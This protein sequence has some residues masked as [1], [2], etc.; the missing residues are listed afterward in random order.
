VVADE[1]TLA[2]TGLCALDVIYESADLR[3]LEQQV[4]AALPQL[5]IETPLD[6]AFVDTRGLAPPGAPCS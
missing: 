1:V 4:R 2:D 3:R 6:P 5:A